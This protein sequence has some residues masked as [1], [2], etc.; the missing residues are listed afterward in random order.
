MGGLLEGEGKGI[1]IQLWGTRGGGE[2][3]GDEP[4]AVPSVTLVLP[5]QPNEVVSELPSGKP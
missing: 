4:P 1:N 5:E 3:G 2:G